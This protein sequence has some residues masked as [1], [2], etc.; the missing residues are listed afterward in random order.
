MK[1][2]NIQNQSCNPNTDFIVDM[3]QRL[4]QARVDYLQHQAHRQTMPVGT[5]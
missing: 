4:R 2:S 1:K 3:Q 5:I